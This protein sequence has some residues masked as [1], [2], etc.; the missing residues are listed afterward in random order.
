MQEVL[1]PEERDR[2]ADALVVGC[3][4]VDEG[5]TLFVYAHPE[6]RE[7]VV[8]I[9]AAGYRA[10]AAIVDVRYADP[11]IQA[12]RVRHGG[13]HVLGPVTAWGT[14]VLREQLKPGSAMAHVLGDAETGI[15]DDL[16]PAR[17]AED[18]MRPLREQAW[19][20]RA[21][22]ADRRRW[23]AIGF[24]TAYWAGVVYPGLDPAAGQR[25]LA[26]DLLWF[27]RLG[28]DDPPGHAG[29]TAHAEGIVRRSEALTALGLERVE[30]RGP[31][32]ELVLGLSPG[33]RWLGGREVNAHGRRVSPNFP[34]EE[35]F[36]SPRAGAAEG[37]FRCSRPLSFHGRELHGLA[38]EF[39]G[40]RLVRLEAAS[41][42]DR[43]HLAA[44]LD[45]DPGARRLGEVALVDR[46]SRIGQTGRVYSN[47]LLDENA[48]AHIAFGFGF[49]SAR[50][51][52]PGKRAAG[53]NRS[54]L[55]LDVMIGTD[56]LEA[57]GIAAGGRRV[58]LIA[59]GEWRI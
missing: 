29:W 59:D 57:T 1:R 42:E 53:V 41:D 21:V 23:A 35:S 30:L 34:T 44:F 40:G 48:A 2:Y 49:D 31:G 10:G 8:A 52:A 36:T 39:R 5:E 47:T 27:C 3:L 11:L 58:P 43:D 24:P 18:T 20:T 50:V 37:T 4:G 7:L 13:D 19:Y 25:K 16:S 46:S 26:D 54:N 9:A 17:V 6:H 38:G 51:V 55:H 15:Y 56:D 22:K 28:P 45:T 32:T 14:R 12:A 33:T